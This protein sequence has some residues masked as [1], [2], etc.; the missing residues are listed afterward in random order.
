MVG[1]RASYK[2]I[3]FYFIFISNAFNLVLFLNFFIEKFVEFMG[4]SSKLFQNTSLDLDT[5][6]SF[7]I[8]DNDINIYIFEISIKFCVDWYIIC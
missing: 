8:P 5:N 7:D 4:S 1:W 3:L 2:R 6:N